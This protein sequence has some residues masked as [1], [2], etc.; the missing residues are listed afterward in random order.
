MD[1]HPEILQPLCDLLIDHHKSECKDPR[2]R[3]FALLGIISTDEREILSTVFPD[4]SMTLD[5]VLVITLA[6]LTQFPAIS[7]MMRRGEKIT[8]DS[9]ELFLGLGVETRSQRSRLLRR[10][11]KLDYLSRMPS[12]QM[13]QLLT[14]HDQMEEYEARM[15]K[16]SKK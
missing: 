4:Y 15:L 2:D 10:A 12:S 1:K 6:H 11:E 3:V 14:W 9:D 5:H 8:P 16:N 13:I 7:R